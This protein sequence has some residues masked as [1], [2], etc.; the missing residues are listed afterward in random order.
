[1]RLG[2][3]CVLVDMYQHL[4]VTELLYTNN[5][6]EFIIYGWM[7]SL[8]TEEFQAAF[9]WGKET[10]FDTFCIKSHYL[11][12]VQWK[13]LAFLW[14]WLKNVFAIPMDLRHW[15]P[16]HGHPDSNDIHSHKTSHTLHILTALFL[17]K[18]GFLIAEA[19]RMWYHVSFSGHLEL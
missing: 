15:S 12:S 6:V 9:L 3:L 18:S 10:V 7:L 16:W 1:M 2:G 19:I 8:H 17:L 13:A 5:W 14:V 4:K 11:Y